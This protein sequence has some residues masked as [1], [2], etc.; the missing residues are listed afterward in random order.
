MDH[1]ECRKTIG[2]LEDDLDYNLGRKEQLKSE[3]KR[4]DEDNDNLRKTNFKNAEVALKKESFLENL[5][6]TLRKQLDELNSGSQIEGFKSKIKVL[7]DTI[8][9]LKKEY[10]ST[11]DCLTH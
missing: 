5:V 2:H 10:V 11:S 1:S 9:S 7:E 4:L 3:V 8:E 6:E